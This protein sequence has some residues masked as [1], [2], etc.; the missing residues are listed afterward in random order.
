MWGRL[1]RSGGC[2]DAGSRG[3]PAS[4]ATLAAPLSL[5]MPTCGDDTAR[6]PPCKLSLSLSIS[7]N[8]RSVPVERHKP[9]VSK[10]ESHR[11][12]S[13]S[14]RGASGG[15]HLG[16]AL[17]QPRRH[18]PGCPRLRPPLPGPAPVIQRL[19][20]TA[21][22][23]PPPNPPA[24]P[25]RVLNLAVLARTPIPFWPALNARSVPPSTPCLARP[26]APIIPGNGLAPA[27]CRPRRRQ[28]VPVR[29]PTQGQ[30]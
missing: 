9:R 10:T 1:E 7:R 17:A 22:I 23:D 30:G 27:P 19:L 16:S 13:G 5:S 6:G 3:R 26:L 15:T 8:C 12:A 20:R 25:D 29:P 28:P 4:C 2:D 11:G 21:L 24:V 14:R 18:V